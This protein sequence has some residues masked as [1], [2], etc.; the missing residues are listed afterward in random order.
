MLAACESADNVSD[1]GVL[2]TEASA[3]NGGSKCTEACDDGGG[4]LFDESLSVSVC[5]VISK[6]VMS[7][8]SEVA[9]STGPCG[10]VSLSTVLAVWSESVL[11]VFGV[12]YGYCA[13]V[14]N[15]ETGTAELVV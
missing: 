12:V 5:Y 13:S 8:D 2:W 7:E 9:V 10:E 6:T 14:A 4:T 11:C 15:G 1:V 3:E